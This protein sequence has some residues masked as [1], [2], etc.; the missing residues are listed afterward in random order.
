M[1]NKAKLSI[2]AAA[3]MVVI[4]AD[5]YDRRKSE[6]PEASK[7]PTRTLSHDAEAIA[8]AQAKRDRKAA[9]LS[10]EVKT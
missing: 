2:L 10:R 4:E 7:S 8:K 5:R 1:K 6:P 9:K 3:L